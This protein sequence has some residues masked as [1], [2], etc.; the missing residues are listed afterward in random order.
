MS[1][2]LGNKRNELS[3][4]HISELTKT[5]GDFVANEYSKIFDNKDFGY[6]KVTVERPER[7]A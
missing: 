2:S 3:S 1:K 6:N 5:Y 7:D 4:S